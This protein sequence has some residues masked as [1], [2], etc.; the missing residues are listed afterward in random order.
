MRIIKVTFE[1]LNSLAGKWEIDLTHPDFSKSPLFVITGPTGSGKT[2][3]LDAIS[4]ALYAR[5][6]RLNR[7]SAS[8]NEIMTRGTSFCMADVVFEASGKTYLAH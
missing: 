8:T 4:L 7:I 3:I 5:T 1:N 2:T 6:A